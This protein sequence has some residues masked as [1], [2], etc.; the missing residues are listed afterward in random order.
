M[1]R[2]LALIIA[3]FALAAAPALPSDVVSF[4]RDHEACHPKGLPLAELFAILKT[5]DCTALVQRRNALLE[6]HKSNPDAVCALRNTVGFVGNETYS[7]GQSPIEVTQSIGA[8]SAEAPT[9]KASAPNSESNP[10]KCQSEENAE[11][12]YV[13]V[14]SGFC[15]VPT[16]APEGSL[17]YQLWHRIC[18]N[19]EQKK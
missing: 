8:P 5:E 10:I 13:I 11:G 18:D 2:W 14:C 19:Q 9:E 1:R 12:A 4:L 7:P 15:S 17:G 16:K 3:G 6:R